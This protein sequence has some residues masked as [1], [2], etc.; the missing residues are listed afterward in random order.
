V[1]V[2]DIFRQDVQRW[3]IPQQ[4]ADPSEVTLV[5]TL[6]LLVQNLSLRAML[7]YRIGAWLHRKGVPYFP[8]AI[9]RFISAQ[10]GLDI[11]VAQEIGGGLYIAHPIGTVISVK[12]L[13]SNCTLISNVTIDMRG[14]ERAFPEVGDRVFIGAGGR[15]MGDI[16]L[17]NDAVIGANAVVLEDVPAGATVVGI[18][19]RQVQR[20]AAEQTANT[21]AAQP[22]PDDK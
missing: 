2:L 17:G 3:I 21:T 5:N 11:S 18:P 20:K 7:W 22:S 16:R 8:G 14:N 15:V 1:N 6:K 19:A 13:G 12:R 4:V 10:F 9:Q